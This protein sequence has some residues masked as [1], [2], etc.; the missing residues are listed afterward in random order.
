MTP[1]RLGEPYA[2]DQTRVSVQGQHP[3]CCALTPAPASP[4]MPLPSLPPLLFPQFP[5]SALEGWVSGGWGA[6]FPTSEGGATFSG[7]FVGQLLGAMQLARSWQCEVTWITGLHPSCLPCAT[8][9]SYP[10]AANLRQL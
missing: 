9:I 6:L 5:F 10:I 4:F 3:L 1:S 8:L 7:T 2:E